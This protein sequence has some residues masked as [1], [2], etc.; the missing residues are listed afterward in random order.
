MCSYERY[1]RDRR[2]EDNLICSYCGRKVPDKEHLSKN[3]CLWCDAE[4]YRRKRNE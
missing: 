4:S 1:M 3:G 2:R